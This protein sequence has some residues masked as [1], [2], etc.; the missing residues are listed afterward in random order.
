V[1]ALGAAFLIGCGGQGTAVTPDGSTTTI[2]SPDFCGALIEAACDRG[3]RCGTAPA[4]RA[5]CRAQLTDQLDECP[6]MAEAV[7]RDEAD[8]DDGAAALYV[9]E[10]RSG[11]CSEAVPD[12]VALGVFTP[13]KEEGQI[14][15][16]KVSCKAGLVCDNHTVETPEGTCRVP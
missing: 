3:A 11:T 8:Y 16:S 1:V 6:F 5:M 15:H 12:P 14:C 10:M 13:R 9:E 2:A 4:D 7:V